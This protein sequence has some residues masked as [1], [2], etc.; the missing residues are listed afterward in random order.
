MTIRPVVSQFNFFT[1]SS[2][3]LWLVPWIEVLCLSSDQPS[4]YQQFWADISTS[5]R[6]QTLFLV[7]W[8]WHAS[9]N[10]VCEVKWVYEYFWLICWNHSR[11]PWY[12][13]QFR[14]HAGPAFSHVQVKV[15]YIWLEDYLTCQHTITQI[16]IT[17]YNVYI[18]DKSS[19]A[20]YC[21]TSL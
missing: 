16:L 20:V 10:F 21:K 14:C 13:M 17:I 1:R 4:N 7:T 19:F 18:G 2:W 11:S 9:S 12:Q 5:L 8:P 15:S 6:R 3:F